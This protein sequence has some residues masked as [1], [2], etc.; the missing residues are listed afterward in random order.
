M[1]S[2]CLIKQR[3]GGA[4]PPY[5]S[6]PVLHSSEIRNLLLK[7]KSPG[8]QHRLQS[9]MQISAHKEYQVLSMDRER[10]F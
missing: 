8:S 3:T 2:L 6:R 10:N 1:C 9:H 4:D 5:Q 7:L